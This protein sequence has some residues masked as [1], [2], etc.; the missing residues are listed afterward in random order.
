PRHALVAHGIGFTDLVKRASSGASELTAAEYRAGYTRVERLTKW[1]QPGA[2][3][4]VG[5]AG[6]RA[7]IDK[8]ATPG[9]Q[10]QR[11]GGRPA[12]VLPSTS[13]RN[14]RVSRSAIVDHLEAAA[15]LATP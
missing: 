6:W 7:A 15:A 3:A 12:Y 14:A 8:R 4:F 2:V 13:G 1:L 10:Q 9:P 5:L 11:V